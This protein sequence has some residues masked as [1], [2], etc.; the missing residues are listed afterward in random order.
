MVK[1]MFKVMVIGDKNVGETALMKKFTH[2]TYQTL[3]AQFSAY[4]SIM[5]GNPVRLL[6][7]NLAPPDR[8]YFV[9]IDYLYREAN[10]AIIV[11]SLE[12][13]E[14]GKESFSHISYW[15]EEMIKHN[16]N[17]PIYLFA[18]KV[19]LVDES[20]VDK[21][22][23]KQVVEQYNLKGYYLTSVIAGNGAIK[24]FNDICTDL[25]KESKNRI[26]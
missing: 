5:D 4:D 16:E 2:S 19:D 8:I 13:T 9:K 21:E 12:D 26:I 20:K 1:F 24:A 23:I 22:S 14:L 10:A 11:Y 18:N 17:I 3:L 7:S 6:F 15:R 25:Y